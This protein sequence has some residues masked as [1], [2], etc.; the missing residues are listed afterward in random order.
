MI[1]KIVKNQTIYEID[2][3]EV[4]EGAIKRY[5][6]TR[7]GLE[8]K[9]KAEAESRIRILNQ[10]GVMVDPTTIQIKMPES[11]DEQR[12]TPNDP[13]LMKGD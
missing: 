10:S 9:K 8:F 6:K 5:L 3:L 12:F 13:D 4:W 1:T 7:Y 2:W 11:L